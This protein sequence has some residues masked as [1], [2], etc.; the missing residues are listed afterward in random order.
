MKTKLIGIIICMLLMAP[1]L[2]A[3]QQQMT[4]SPKKN[5]QQE[6]VTTSLEDTPIWN[7]GDKWAYRIDDININFENNSY[8]EPKKIDVHLEIDNFPLEV[9][10]TSGNFYTVQIDSTIVNGGFTIDIDLGHGPINV[11]GEFTQGISPT[12]IEGT[13]LFNKTTLGIAEISALIDGRM[14]FRI[15]DQPYIPEFPS[16]KIPIPAEIDASADLSIPLTLIKFPMDNGSTWGLPERNVTLS[17]TMK[18]VWLKIVHFIYR[19]AKF[20]DEYSLLP[21]NWSEM[22]NNESF[23]GIMDLLPNVDIAAAFEY[24]NISNPIYVPGVGIDIFV[25]TGWELVSVEAGD[26]MAYN[27]TIANV[28]NVYY[29][30]QVKNIVKIDGI[31]EDIIPYVSD[32]RMELID[33]EV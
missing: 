7:L 10:D 6:A 29:S 24:F 30:P 19:C 17:G 2:A 3:T 22:I 16:P 13:I 15:N 25:C 27:I 18:S 5:E 28:G 23:S 8:D 4:N 21:K 32:I 14:N 33:I 20:L 9:A 12:K 26:F 31:F 11:T 1:I